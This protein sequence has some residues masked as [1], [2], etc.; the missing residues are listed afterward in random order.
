MNNTIGRGRSFIIGSVVA[1]ALT[2]SGLGLA[3]TATAAPGG[4][5]NAEDTVSRLTSQG[6]NVALNHN[7]G[8]SDVPLSQCI[9]SGIHGLVSGVPQGQPLPQDQQ[10]AQTAYVD[11]SCSTTE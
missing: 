9:V 11:V 10:G 3:A 8:W 4:A 1:G 6:Y 7:G 2:L 5:S